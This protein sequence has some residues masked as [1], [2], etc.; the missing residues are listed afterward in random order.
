MFSGTILV[1][2]FLGYFNGNLSFSS[3]SSGGGFG[4]GRQPNAV[5]YL[6][7]RGLNSTGYSPIDLCE[8]V[9]LATALTST[10]FQKAQGRLAH[11]WGTTALLPGGHPYKST[12][13]YV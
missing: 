5:R 9:V 6:G 2:E 8:V 13:P 3:T 11:K 10:D 1:P 7:Y 4:S 12:P